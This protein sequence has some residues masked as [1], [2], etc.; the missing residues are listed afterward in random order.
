MEINNIKTP[1][2]STNTSESNEIDK[3][4]HNLINSMYN[5]SKNYL[6]KK[7]NQRKILKTV[8]TLSS[9]II[10][11]GYAFKL[12][13]MLTPNLTK[14]VYTQLAQAFPGLINSIDL[15]PK[16]QI[17]KIS[18]N[19]CL[20]SGIASGLLGKDVNDASINAFKSLNSKD[21]L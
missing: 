12:L 6:L 10:L 5:T 2:I 11:G 21:L 19:L 9:S 8:G 14:S 18:S 20:F 15:I 13:P 17:R 3:D 16:N 7:E 4:T 1:S